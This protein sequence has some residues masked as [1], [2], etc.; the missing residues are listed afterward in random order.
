MDLIL[1]RHAEA[2][3]GVPD[4]ARKLTPKGVKQAK[5]IAKW[6]RPRL[7]ADT[8]VIVSP[9]RRALQTAEA[10]GMECVTA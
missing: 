8:R 1:W 6:L 10:L 4:L 5:R 7:P 3:D 9:A 2:E